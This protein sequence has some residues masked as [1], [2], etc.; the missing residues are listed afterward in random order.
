MR[1]KWRRAA[2]AVAEIIRSWISGWIPVNTCSASRA[3]TACSIFPWIAISTGELTALITQ[4]VSWQNARKTPLQKFHRTEVV[5]VSTYV[6]IK[7]SRGSKE[8]LKHSRHNVVNL[9]TNSPSNGSVVVSPGCLDF[10]DCT[11]FSVSLRQKL[12][13]HSVCL[14]VNFSTTVGL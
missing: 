1:G 11:I 12:K 5:Q 7:C 13:T 9:L 4:S 2:G 8:F 3:A 14:V 6:G 10:I